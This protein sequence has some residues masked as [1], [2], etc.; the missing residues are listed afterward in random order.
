MKPKLSLSILLL[1]VLLAACAQATPTEPPAV[2]APT[3]EPPTALPTPLPP[4]VT[5]S[6]P[7]TAT[8][9]PLPSPTLSP[10]P[11]TPFTASALAENV[12][13]R[14]N[15]GYLFRVLVMVP[16]GT[17]FLVLGKSPGGEWILVQLSTN[18]TGWVFAQLIESEVEV[19]SAPV[20]Q[21]VD[22]QLI[23]G[24]VV[25][26]QGQPV[27]GI[28]FALTQG[29]GAA[30]PRTDAMTDVNGIFFA[31]LPSTAT[32]DWTV[33]FTAIACSSSVMDAE[34][35]CKGGTCGSIAPVLQK[36]TLPV[37]EALTFTWK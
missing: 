17:K 12:N 28:Q 26:E 30:A 20:I 11:F 16:K 29:E 25:D 35:N 5:A 14:S 4:T 1:A 9:T 19:Q 21:P 23:S 24:R 3:E 27:N 34:C 22:A 18:V 31:Y 6:P 36:I 2:P 8:L 33:S 32:G 13:V 10:T 37:K 7:P 15:P